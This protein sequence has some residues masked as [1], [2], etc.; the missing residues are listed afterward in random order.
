MCHMPIAAMCSVFILSYFFSFVCTTQRPPQFDVLKLWCNCSHSQSSVCVLCSL[1]HART[2]APAVPACWH[3][4]FKSDGACCALWFYI[5]F[6]HGLKFLFIII[7]VFIDIFITYL[8]IK[9]L[10][11]A[12]GAVHFWSKCDIEVRKPWSDSGSSGNTLI[13]LI[14]KKQFI[15]DMQIAIL[16]HLS[17]ACSEYLQWLW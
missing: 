13:I 6:K 9:S 14:I 7:S 12:I 8:C 17:G 2:H 1:T 10:C 5:L 15:D 4:D 16:Y 3:V 11:Y